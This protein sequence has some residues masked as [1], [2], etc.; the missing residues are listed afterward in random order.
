MNKKNILN[1]NI[2]FIIAL[3]FDQFVKHIIV[4]NN[5]KID[6][7][8]NILSINYHENYGIAFS[9]F[10]N[11]N[12]ITILI[13]IILIILLTSIIHKDFVKR[14]KYTNFLNITFAILYAGIIGNL[15]DRIFNGYVI[16]YIDL[17][18]FAVFNLADI[19]ITYG[20]L[21]LLYKFIKE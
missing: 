9:L 10:E 4:K 21:I 15:I 1:F 13:S 16:D 5:Y 6:L 8:K 11:N 3:F 14:N 12:L 20:I 2:I 19:Y 17:S 7:I 18:F